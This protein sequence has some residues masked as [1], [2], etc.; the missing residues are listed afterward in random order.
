MEHVIEVEDG[1]AQVL[2]ETGSGGLIGRGL[3]HERPLAEYVEGAET[4]R[5]VVR[6]KKRGFTVERTEG[7]ANDGGDRGTVNAGAEQG[8]A[9]GAAGAV[10]TGQVAPDGDHSAAA[11]VTDTRVLFAA[12]RA[13]GDR[14]RSVPLADVVDARTEAGLLDETLVLDLVSGAQYRFPSRGDLTAV[15][16]FVDAAAGI[17]SS[18][19]RRLESAAETLDRIERAFEAGD[20]DVVLAAVGDVRE[21]LDEAREAAAPLDGAAASVADRAGDYRER[22]AAF[23]RRAYA[24]Q[25][26]Q[27]R[28]R[29]HT[30]WDDH[31]Y[32]AAADHFERAVDS[33]AAALSVDADRP[34]D[35]LIER[36]RANL[37]AE[38]ERLA[39]APLER[40][41]Q[42]VEMARG[43]DDLETAEAWWERALERYER[44]HALDWGRDE[45][46]FEGDREAVRERLAMVARQ[47]VET[48]CERARRA[49]DAA[50]D[51][52]PGAAAAACERAESSLDAARSVAR[53][54]VPDALDGVEALDERL[55]DCRPGP[56]DNEVSD[57]G[58]V[59]VSPGEGGRNADGD[60]D[61]A[62]DAD[63]DG[64]GG[65]VS[66]G[67][68]AA[69]GEADDDASAAMGDG[70]ML[71]DDG[72]DDEWL[73]AER[74]GTAD[75]AAGATDADTARSDA[76]AADTDATGQSLD[77]DAGADTTDA[78]RV[79]DA[80]ESA[81]TVLGNGA[82]G[83]DGAD[84][85]RDTSGC[86]T[87]GG[88]EG[89]PGAGV[90]DGW[91]PAALAAL[92]AEA[93]GETVADCL[94]ATGWT[95]ETAGGGVVDDGATD[96]PDLRA[97]A[98][99]PV[100]VRAGVLA[101][102]ADEASTL[103]EAAVDR[104]AAA[105]ERD[106]RLDAAVLV[107]GATLP[108]AVRERAAAA[109]VD[110]VEPDALVDELDGF[111]VPAP[112]D[113]RDPDRE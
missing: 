24:E 62:E 25:A 105:V 107:A 31:A 32:E 33:Y 111:G 26:E 83:A 74:T 82:D 60:T 54:R 112:D 38:R 95:V 13:G 87:R 50:E 10:D 64:G 42:A 90:S 51:A 108:P 35:E 41:E 30:R 80:A 59:V 71:A 36:R 40:A 92:G 43:A 8:V 28:E 5:F 100:D 45:P 97:T 48:R 55:A 109:G 94:R 72:G 49:L 106:D 47:L 16:E 84:E 98:P 75:D 77:A 52:P 29:G 76:D 89:G 20:A 70:W 1:D 27:A 21:T 69:T 104:L 103:D 37:V 102:P 57:A 68:D 96:G 44:V 81:D 63:A 91:T 22:L 110:V 93:F 58:T 86:T 12:G 99:G 39:A 85:P 113:E 3:L 34:D 53:E 4:P 66:G 11:L 61:A 23:E 7:D 88:P 17:W 46:R 19:E 79:A 78:E 67:A 101:V 2:T 65:T 6:N 73:S 15:R 18:A 14:T 9:N 56:D